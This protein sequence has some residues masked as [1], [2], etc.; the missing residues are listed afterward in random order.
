MSFKLKDL[1]IT[2]VDFVDAGANQRANILITKKAQEGGENMDKENPVKKFLS[3]IADKLGLKE[4]EVADSI[5]E[6]S[7]AKTFDEAFDEQH[8][9]KVANE[10]DELCCALACSM[11]SILDDKEAVNKG[12]LIKQSI[13]DFCN[14]AKSCADKWGSSKLA[15]IKKKDIADDDHN[16]DVTKTLGDGVVQ[17]VKEEIDMKIDKSLL[18]AAERAFLEEIEKKAGKEDDVKDEIG[19]GAPVGADENADEQVPQEGDVLKCIPEKL[20]NVIKSMESKLSE[21]EDKELAEVAKKYEILGVKSE[22]MVPMLKSLKTN[23]A[24]YDAVL[25]RFD[26]AVSAVEKSG[27]FAEIGKRGTEPSDGDA[28]K[29]IEKHA[30]DIVNAHPEIGYHKAIDM[31]CQQHPDLVREYEAQ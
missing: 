9:W 29:K 6:I 16:D 4:N 28:W 3:T 7:K 11:R 15:G 22:D 23:Q 25:K 14:T 30:A 12:D 1:L 2:K 20:A 13:D 21:Y 8:L 31:A 5:A 26:D 18:T 27:I 24:A 10:M 19:K 17:D